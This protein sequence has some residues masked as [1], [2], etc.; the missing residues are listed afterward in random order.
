MDKR[1]WLFSP[2]DNA[3]MWDE[4]YLDGYMGIGWLRI[5]DLNN[6]NS[7][8]EILAKLK[9]TAKPTD[10][11][12]PTNNA[13]AN[14]EFKSVMKPGDIV[15]VKKG[16]HTLLGYGTV[17]SDYYFDPSKDHYQKCR[18]VKWEKKGE[19]NHDHTLG[20]K[21][22]TDVT[23]YPS[24]NPKY[25]LYYQWLLGDM[26]GGPPPPPDR[27]EHPL[28]VI[29][30]GPPGT[31]KTYNTVYK[32]L[33]ILG[34][35]LNGKSRTE[36]KQLFDDKMREGQI[37]F[38]TFHQSM[39]YEDFIEGIKPITINEN[40][41][42]EIKDGLFKLIC[43]RARNYP[44]LPK[45]IKSKNA[46]YTLV[47]ISDD[48]YIV[49]TDKG[50]IVPIPRGLIEEVIYAVSKQIL[51][52]DDI[53]KNTYKNADAINSKYD[54]YI[55]G[56]GSVLYALYNELILNTNNCEPYVL[57]ID[58]INRGNVSQIFGELITVIEQDKRLGN[59]EALQITLPYSK[60]KFGVPPNLY[61]IGTMNTA[62]RSVEALDTALRRRFDFEYTPPL[63][64]IR[65]EDGTDLMGREIDGIN[66]S[67]L[68]K[69]INDRIE[70]LLD[71]DHLI[72]HSY[73]M[74]SGNIKD[75]KQAF[76]NR[77][78][79]L[80]QEYFFGDPGKI[81]L[82]LGSGF[83][84]KIMEEVEFASCDYDL[85]DLQ[86]RPVYRIRNLRIDEFTNALKA[87]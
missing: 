23:K 75:L 86:E 39:S 4:F 9:E 6:Y 14:W 40:I 5:G 57:I 26:N 44:K 8:D 64:S 67:K 84:E 74:Q 60:E 66:L 78:I 50:K 76:D 80:L 85:D 63:Y 10:S 1:Y 7:K 22:L 46:E 68:L 79:P 43:F 47:S 19:W 18:K 25:N 31:G 51:E 48:M 82:V 27:S 53:I 69:T 54:R 65:G 2:G 59:P 73:F 38:T 71:K 87:L 49:E 11:Q 77:I 58:E 21:T 45:I 13:T 32:A 16:T 20:I 29:L 33:E 56:Y 62:D 83:I 52:L 70:K 36:I 17:D 41:R 61:I 24:E 35:D 72:G 15:I 30:Y 55:F 3:K 34:M 37:V 28:N 42:Y 12:N 81:G